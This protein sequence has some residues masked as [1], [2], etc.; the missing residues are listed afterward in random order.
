M[1][2]ASKIGLERVAVVGS[3]CS[4]KTTLARELANLLGASYIELD[5]V[6]W[7]A[8]WKPR[9]EADFRQLV[10]EAVSADRWVV[11]GNYSVVRDLIWPRAT[12]VVWLNYPF[13]LVFPRALSRTIRRAITREELYSGNRESLRKAF[14]SSDSILLWVI[15]S[16]RRHQRDYETLRESRTYPQIRF[17]ELRRPSEATQLLSSLGAAAPRSSVGRRALR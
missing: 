4:G 13:R 10:E 1:R 15:T 9:P 2:A 17:W 5:S 8:D 14:F 7:E 3:S 12:A 16:F 6:Y 11:D